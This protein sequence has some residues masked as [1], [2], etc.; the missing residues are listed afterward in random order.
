M[1]GVGH[2]KVLGRIPARHVYFNLGED[3]CEDGNG[4]GHFEDMR[5]GDSGDLLDDIF[6]EWDHP[7]DHQESSNSV[8][9]DG[10]ALTVLEGTVTP[11]VDVL[12]GLDVLQDW[13]AEISM[14]QKQ[15]I[16]VKKRRRGSSFKG[17]N[18]SVVIPFSSRASSSSSRASS[19]QGRQV[20][21]GA[22]SRQRRRHDPPTRP[23]IPAGDRYRRGNPPARHPRPSEPD[24]AV[25]GEDD[26]EE[27]R[28]YLS[29]RSSTIESD[30]DLLD[31]T[32]PREFPRSGGGGRL[33]QM[34]IDEVEEG[35]SRRGACARHADVVGPGDGPFDPPAADESRES[36][37]DEEDD[38]L[39]DVEEDME[40]DE[41]DC[42]MSGL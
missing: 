12:L 11:G 1:S 37:E 42:D 14:G 6:D 19:A 36:E 39:P 29:P 22:A 24:P 34:K 31:Q 5:G 9:M 20:R 15:S 2:C 7:D 27:E 28:F 13:E 4:A 17:G 21:G 40:D 38:Y 32:S 33:T 35:L 30:L 41:F 23:R 18:S 8:Q 16:T 26:D 25:D 3:Y 10:P